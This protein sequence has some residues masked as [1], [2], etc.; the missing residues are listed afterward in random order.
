MGEDPGER[1]LIE[2]LHLLLT[3]TPSRLL[4][5]SVTDLVGDRRTQ[6]QPGTD[7]EYPNWRIP[8]TD[9]DGRPVL[10]EDLATHPRAVS[11]ASRLPGR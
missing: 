4:G 11:L 6:N 1:E 3:R 8:L 2:A 7:T 10:L 5:V 9:H